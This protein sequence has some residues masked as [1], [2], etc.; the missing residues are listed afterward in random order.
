MADARAR[1]SRV[2]GTERAELAAAL[3]RR[4]AA[5]ESVRALA[6]DT[7][8]SFGFV[9]G[10]LTEAGVALRA[11]GG[12][13]RGVAATAARTPAAA[14]AAP[15]ADETS[16]VGKPSDGK[17]KN[18]K[19]EDSKGKETEDSKGKEGKDGKGKGK[20]AKDGKRKG[21]K[22]RDTLVKNGK[23]GR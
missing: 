23:S 1:G 14:P 17:H 15:E 12:P 22:R 6:Q 21:A 2:T 3:G 7:G 8:R 10:L 18:K 16:G 11:R 20:K 4:Y 19:T 9:H 13:T 5:G